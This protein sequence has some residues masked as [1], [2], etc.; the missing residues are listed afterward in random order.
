MA[1]TRTR[2]MLSRL[3]CAL[4]L[5]S[6]LHA[7]PAQAAD[8]LLMFVLGFAKNLID[9]HLEA[10]AQKRPRAPV[11]V[12]LP[13]VKAPASMDAS[14]LRALVDESFVYLSAAQRAELLAGLDKALSDPANS[15]QRPAIL[16]QFVNVARQVSFT[17]RQLDRLSAAD[18][19]A[20]AERFAANYRTLA[21]EQQQQLLQQLRAR[22][23]PVPT[24]LNDMMLLAL[25]P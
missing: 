8:P 15:A 18:K 9:S 14:D 25:A 3:G 5:G 10:E 23:L 21:P 16:S 1:S 2:P 6:V 7:A 12:P 20:L 4:L 19:R 22:A 13:L 11:P 24:D 17:H